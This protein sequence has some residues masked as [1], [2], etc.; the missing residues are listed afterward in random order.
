MKKIIA[1]VLACLLVVSLFAACGEKK[2]V[3]EEA[4]DASLQTVLNKGELVIGTSPDF[5]PFENLN[6]DGSITG[7]EIDILSK[8]CEKLGV[9]LKIEPYDFDAIL[10]GLD[11]GKY[12]LAVS[13]ITATEERKENALFTDAYCLSAISLVVPEGS[14]IKGKDD[15]ADKTISCQTGTTAEL[16]CNNNG[17]K[18][19][20]FQANADAQMALTTGKV[21]VWAIDKL[22]AVD[23]VATYNDEHDD[24]LVVLDEPLT[25]EPYAFASKLGNDTLIEAINGALAELIA[26]GTVKALFESYDAEYVD[27]AV[28]PTV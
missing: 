15:I 4:S 13:G 21:D 16:Y 5:P 17:L 28:D 22:T 9:V 24:K 10:T 23:M 3:E 25:Y 2:P 11:A 6:D 8:I 19:N 20:A 14:E 7:I 26:D 27:P 1:L 12:D 18:N